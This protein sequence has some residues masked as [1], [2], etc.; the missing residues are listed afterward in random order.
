MYFFPI[1]QNVEPTNKRY[2]LAIDV[3]GSMTTGGCNGAS[4]ISPSVASAAMAMV[5][6]RTENSHKFVGFSHEIVPL[7]IDSEMSLERV[8]TVIHRVWTIFF[9]LKS[10]PPY[11]LI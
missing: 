7:N 9:A 5:T 4:S 10:A 8:I 6:A 2:L 3:S 11:V 1:F